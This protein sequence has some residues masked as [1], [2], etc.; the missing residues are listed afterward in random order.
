MS[1][2]EQHYIQVIAESRSFTK[3]A[4]RLFVSQPSLSHLVAKA[5]KRLGVPLFDR[6]TTPLTLT[7]AGEV[8]LRYARQQA[9]AEEM[10]ER[11]FRDICNTRSG[12]IRIGFP[13]ERGSYL[14]PEVLPRFLAEYPDFQVQIEEGN[15][16]TLSYMLQHGQIDFAVMPLLHGLEGTQSFQIGTEELLLVSAPGH[17][18]LQPS[19]DGSLPEIPVEALTGERFIIPRKGHTIREMLDD[20]LSVHDLHPEILAEF[21]SQLTIYRLS[22]AG[23]GISVLP[24]ILVHQMQPLQKADICRIASR[25]QMNWPV[26]IFFRQNSYIGKAE[27]FLMDTLRDSF[28]KLCQG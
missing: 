27:Q 25:T 21:S 6:S 14:L 3:A 19:P 24:N 8:Y 7:Y 18:E 13:G 16:K 2:R 5:E 11:E 9:Q 1:S 10:L 28:Q 26:G 4:E 15:R 20:F 22:A 12:R 23:L 17:F